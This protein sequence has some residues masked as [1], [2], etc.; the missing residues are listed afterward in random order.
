MVVKMSE[1]NPDIKH[2]DPTEL[3]YKTFVGF[4]HYCCDACENENI[5]Y[6][7]DPESANKC[8]SCIDKLEPLYKSKVPFDFN[9]KTGKII[10]IEN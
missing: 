6:S 8:L 2:I 1:N 7:T 5:R 4:L 10:K 3:E 9:R